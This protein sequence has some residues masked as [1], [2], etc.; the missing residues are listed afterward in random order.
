MT[1]AEKRQLI[2]LLNKYQNELLSE[3]NLYRYNYGKKAQYNHARIIANRLSNEKTNE[4]IPY[5]NYD[6]EKLFKED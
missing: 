5:C 2:Y 4:L 6:A 1:G 3:I